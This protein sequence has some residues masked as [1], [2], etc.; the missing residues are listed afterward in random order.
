[1]TIV[2][3]A[4]PWSDV[5]ANMQAAITNRSL[6]RDMLDDIEQARAS[7]SLVGSPEEAWGNAAIPG[8]GIG[9]PVRAPELDPEA[10][11]PPIAS[12]D[13]A[14]AA[15][16]RFA[17]APETLVLASAPGVPL[18][19]AHGIPTAAVDRHQGRFVV[20]LLGA[21]VAIASAMALALLVTGAFGS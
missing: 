10:A 2:G 9:L 6:D 18:L 21:V 7:G 1:V 12:A 8:F 13:E 15:E 5:Q 14:L 11:P 16:R 4:L 3:Q 17:I 20:G 19:I